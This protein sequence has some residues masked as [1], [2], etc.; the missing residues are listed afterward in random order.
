MSKKVISLFSIFFLVLSLFALEVMILHTNDHHGSLYSYWYE[1]N[2]VAG[3]AERANLIKQHTEG[4]DNFLLLDA[5]DFNTGVYESNLYHA[6]PDITAYNLIGYHAVTLGN[7]EFYGDLERVK[8]QIDWADFSMLSANVFSL[9][10]ELV[11]E[12]YKIFTM[13]NGLRVAVFGLTTTHKALS[14]DFIVKDDVETARDLVPLLRSEADIVIA[15]TH[16]GIYDLGPDNLYGS[17][18]LATHVEGI[19]LIIDGDSHTYLEA[20]L[21]VNNTPIV[22]AYDRG[23][24]LGKAMINFDET[25]GTVS[26]TSWEAIPLMRSYNSEEFEVDEAVYNA[27]EVFRLQAIEEGNELIG[28]T[29]RAFRN[30]H[31]QN[32]IIALGRVVCEAIKE[33]GISAGHN[34]D[35]SL[36]NSGAIRYDL[37]IGDIR[38]SDIYNILPYADELVLIEMPGTVLLDIIS[39]SF[40]EKTDTGGFLQYSSNVGIIQRPPNLVIPNLSGNELQPDKIY[41]VVTPAYLIDG[42]DG[43]TQFEYADNRIDLGISPREALIEYIR[44]TDSF[45]Q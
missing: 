36:Y 37:M 19:D 12:A 39:T 21:Y 10:G 5:G 38:I 43:Y 25:D 15:L 11:G 28:H 3:L 45:Q 26:L 32:R 22:Q 16:I 4:I 31:V 23:K 35:V 7:H 29:E 20:P 17:I 27:L 24:Y 41:K 30:A 14:A 42:G 8:K 1:S 2:Q 9:E 6:Q 44:N 18:R 33:A 40:L 13:T 34:V